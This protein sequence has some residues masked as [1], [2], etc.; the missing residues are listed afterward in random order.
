MK[1]HVEDFLVRR[2]ELGMDNRIRVQALCNYMEEAA[3]NHAAALGVGLEHL[4]E[5]GLTWVLAKMRM[6]F[7]RFPAAGE[8]I[9]LETWPVAVERLRFRRDFVLRD[10]QGARCMAG[11]TQWVVLGLSSR[12]IERMPGSVSHLHPQTPRHAVEE[13]DIRIPAPAPGPEAAGPSFPVRL[14]DIDQNHHVNNVRYVD[15]T[16]EA[17][18]DHGV[19]GTLRRL[20]LIF[21]AEGLRGDVITV[22]TADEEGASGSLVHS[23]RRAGDGQELARARSVWE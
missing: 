6:V 4:K 5:D 9:C 15:F 18:H 22:V 2:T 3:G 23:I 13:G 1:T 10:E 14:A 21:R 8:R 7:T 19:C 20:D 11:V 17:A 16:L 12:R